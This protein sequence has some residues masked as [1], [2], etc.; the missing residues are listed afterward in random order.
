MLSGEVRAASWLGADASPGSCRNPRNLLLLRRAG[1]SLITKKDLY[2][3]VDR[4]TQG[5]VRQPLPTSNKLPTLCFAAKEVGI[6]LVGGGAGAGSG[7]GVGWLC[8]GAWGQAEGAGGGALR[9][10][11][12]R[13]LCE[14]GH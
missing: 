11:S 7:W 6:A 8:A 2:A 5:E 9:W 14:C 1:R 13:L 10:R 3:G 12:W 4:F